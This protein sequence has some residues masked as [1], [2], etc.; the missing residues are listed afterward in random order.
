MCPKM[1]FTS[2]TDQVWIDNKL[3]IDN[4]GEVKGVSHRDNCVA[5]AK[6]L[7]PVKYIFIANITGGWPSWWNEQNI[8]LRKDGTE[9]FVNI[10]NDQLF[11]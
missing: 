10:A 4:S 6:G 2:R 7:H 5:L 3:V 8:Q 11:H 1:V 9:Q